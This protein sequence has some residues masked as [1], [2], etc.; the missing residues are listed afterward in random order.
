MKKYY[1]IWEGHETGIYDS[2]EDCR[3]LIE[4]YPK[5]RYKSFPSRQAAENAFYGSMDDFH[6]GGTP[7]KPCGHPTY[8]TGKDGPILRSLAVDAAC[9]GNPGIM[10]YQGVWVDSNHRAF[11]KGPFPMGTANIGEFL[12]IVHA[13]A[14]LKQQNS[15]LPIYSDSKI[16]ISWIA[17]GVAKTKLE[18]THK[19]ANLYTI[20][21]RAEHWLKK[22][23]WN[24]KILKWDTKNWGEIPAD[25]GNK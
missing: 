4:G 18:H 11:H 5:A 22:N 21:K 14:Y 7:V 10:E 6:T 13:L 1:V 24:N 12:A 17:Q 23:Q 20:I 25:F 3:K 19:T 16:A 8:P 15:T 9:K 2:W